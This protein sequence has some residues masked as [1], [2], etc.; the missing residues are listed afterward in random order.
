MWKAG[1]RWWYASLR[2]GEA[3]GVS[4][5]VEAARAAKK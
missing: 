3:S 2:A 5:R 4:G 1:R